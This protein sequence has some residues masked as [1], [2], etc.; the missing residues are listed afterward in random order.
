MLHLDGLIDYIVSYMYVEGKYHGNK[1]MRM[2]YSQYSPVQ[3]V[4]ET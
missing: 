2:G 3:T 4:P 1:H